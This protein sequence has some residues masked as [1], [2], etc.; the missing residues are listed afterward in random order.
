VCCIFTGCPQVMAFTTIPSS[1]SVFM[2]YWLATVSQLTPLLTAISR[3]SRN[4]SCSSLYSISTGHRGNTSPK[5][6]SIVASC[7][8]HADCIENTTFQLLHCCLLQICCLET[9]CL[10]SHS[11]GTAVS[12]GF[13]VLAFSKY[14][15]LLRP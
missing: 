5:R 2:S 8:Y 14:A 11:L 7:S 12:A 4:R 15:T 6:Y 1:V 13:T 9:D 10:Q 3:L